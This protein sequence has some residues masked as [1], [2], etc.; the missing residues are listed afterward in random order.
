MVMGRYEEIGNAER[1]QKVRNDPQKNERKVIAARYGSRGL[2]Y[3][4]DSIPRES[5]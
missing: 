3:R 2:A 1:V 4:E 5:G